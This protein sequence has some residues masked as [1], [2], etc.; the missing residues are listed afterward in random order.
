MDFMGHL[1]KSVAKSQ[2]WPRDKGGRNGRGGLISVA[3]F[4]IWSRQPTP[5]TALKGIDA[6]LR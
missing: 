2:W 5:G 4:D 1:L 3:I 6:G